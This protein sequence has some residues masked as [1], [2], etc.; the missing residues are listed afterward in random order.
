MTG[1]KLG[2]PPFGVFPPGPF[3]SKSWLKKSA[4]IRSFAAVGPPG[5]INLCAGDPAPG[6]P[7]G[8][9]TDGRGSCGGSEGE[10]FNR[11]LL[12]D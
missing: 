12:S 2:D 8:L 7:L 6:V 10:E 11:L 1:F 4:S 3:L 5:V 9:L